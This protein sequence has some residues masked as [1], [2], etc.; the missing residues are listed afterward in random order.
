MNPPSGLHSTVTSS[1]FSSQYS[2]PHYKRTGARPDLYIDIGIGNG[3]GRRSRTLSIKEGFSLPNS[4]RHSEAYMHGHGVAKLRFI[5]VLGI[6][7]KGLVGTGIACIYIWL[8]LWH[9]AWHGNAWHVRAMIPCSLGIISYVFAAI[10]QLTCAC[11]VLSSPFVFGDVWYRYGFS[12]KV[13]RSF[14]NAFVFCLRQ[15]AAS[16]V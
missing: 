15:L 7:C 6:V 14:T 9:V 8:G 12:D 1:L 2:Q 10:L 16:Y 4:S 5:G 11:V 3:I 13:S